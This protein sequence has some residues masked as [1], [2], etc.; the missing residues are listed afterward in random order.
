MQRTRDLA[1]D[2][3][4]RARDRDDLA[5][6]GRTVGRTA[7]SVRRCVRPGRTYRQIGFMR[8]DR[9]G[10]LIACSGTRDR[11]GPGNPD[12]Q[13]VR[14]GRRAF[15]PPSDTREVVVRLDAYPT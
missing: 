12:T 10:V 1:A 13:A 8:L 14:N 6:H 15:K 9:P 7:G 3:D 11:R 4:I 2:A 5:L